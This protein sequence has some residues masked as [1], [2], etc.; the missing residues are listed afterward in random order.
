MRAMDQ[1]EQ[2]RGECAAVDA[3]L[4]VAVGRML[5][6]LA[7]KLDELEGRLEDLQARSPYVRFDRPRSPVSSG[8]DKP[9]DSRCLCERR[10]LWLDACVCPAKRWRAAQGHSGWRDA[11]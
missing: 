5:G 2:I 6:V 1:L 8:G 11:A 9:I 10:D 7:A 4:S 3:P